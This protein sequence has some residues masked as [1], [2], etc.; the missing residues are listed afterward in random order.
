MAARRFTRAEV[1]EDR[2]YGRM[3]IWRIAPGG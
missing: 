1:L 2:T 3:E